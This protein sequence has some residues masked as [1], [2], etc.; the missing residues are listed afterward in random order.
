MVLSGW[1]LS[2]GAGIGGKTILLPVL[3]PDSRWANSR[4]VALWTVTGTQVQP[5]AEAACI[6]QG[7][8]R[9]PG[10]S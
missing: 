3:R 1:G 2:V 7:C 6:S 8:V 4:L 5:W 10:T 9:S